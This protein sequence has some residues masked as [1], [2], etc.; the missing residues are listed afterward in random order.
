MQGTGAS[1]QWVKIISIFGSPLS[2]FLKIEALI[3]PSVHYLLDLLMATI[4]S[5][6]GK[7]T[8]GG[9]W[10]RERGCADLYHAVLSHSFS[11]DLGESEGLSFEAQRHVA[12]CFDF[13][14]L[15]RTSTDIP[16]FFMYPVDL[17]Q[18]SFSWGRRPRIRQMPR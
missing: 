13:G 11:S 1:L 2:R 18:K 16:Y 10:K 12:V 7:L 9:R 15:A 17:V 8:E 3:C 6:V 14:S 4:I 5:K